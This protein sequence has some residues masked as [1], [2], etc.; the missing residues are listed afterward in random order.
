MRLPK[1]I[2]AAVVCLLV[3]AL[4]SPAVFAKPVEFKG[5]KVT[6]DTDE[7]AKW[8][9]NGPGDDDE[10]HDDEDEWVQGS[11]TDSPLFGLL[12]R[13]FNFR[14]PTGVITAIHSSKGQP[15]ITIKTSDNKLDTYNAGNGVNTWLDGKKAKLDDLDVGDRVALILNPSGHVITIIAKSGDQTA[16][17]PGQWQSGSVIQTI[18]Q[19][20]LR[21]LSVQQQSGPNSY[22]L[23]ANAQVSFR[24][25]A[26]GTFADIRNGDR[27]TFR[28]AD[29]KIVELVV[30]TETTSDVGQITAISAN[31]VTIKRDSGSSQTYALGQGLTLVIDG[32]T[33]PQISD[34]MVGDRAQVLV[35]DGIVRSMHVTPA[36]NVNGTVVAVIN[37]SGYRAISIR[38]PGG[39]VVTH[40]LTTTAKVSFEGWAAGT[41][42]DIR[43]GDTVHARVVDDKITNLIVVTVTSTDAGQITAIS[44]SVISIRRQDG[45]LKA[46]PLDS[47]ITLTI[48]GATNPE[49]SDVL[50]GD[51]VE[52]LIRDGKVRAMHVTPATNLSGT[53]ETIGTTGDYR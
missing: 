10:D 29:G 38:K 50:V 26:A 49:L 19:G 7:I 21:V 8:L 1:S 9:E 40:A 27:V 44:S 51:Q 17:T 33:N 6:I 31:S 4:S 47:N 43:E 45:T 30:E 36:A 34:V 11:L 23:A 5:G 22:I 15:T 18:Y 32:V 2:V 28:L 16:P 42:A 41:F 14:V 52:L 46:Y 3:L 12:S 13:F 37:T 53:V 35:R 39:V 24:N 48:K 25:W 20:S